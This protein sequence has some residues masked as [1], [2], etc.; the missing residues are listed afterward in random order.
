M[1]PAEERQAIF[2]CVIL[3]LAVFVCKFLCTIALNLF[4]YARIPRNGSEI[5]LV[6][7]GSTEKV[8]YTSDN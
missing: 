6:Q 8:M 7:V 2:A 1:W 3:L 4:S 5:C